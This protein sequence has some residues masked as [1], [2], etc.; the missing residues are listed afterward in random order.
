MHM[1]APTPDEPPSEA[2]GGRG[3]SWKLEAGSWSV[4]GSSFE[5]CVLRFGRYRRNGSYGSYEM[6]GGKGESIGQGEN[7][8]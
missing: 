7:L 6:A 8:E 2:D 1:P 5:F 3:R 4:L